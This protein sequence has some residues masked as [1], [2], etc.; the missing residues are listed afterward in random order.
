MRNV[1]NGLKTKLKC[2]CMQDPHLGMLVEESSTAGGPALAGQ[3]LVFQGKL[4]VI[5]DFFSRNNPR[6]E[7]WRIKNQL[8]NT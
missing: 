5:S 3:L 4:V 1:I 7:D 8:R 2:A 6:M